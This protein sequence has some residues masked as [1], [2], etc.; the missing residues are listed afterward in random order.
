M[1]P[2]PNE[3]LDNLL[4]RG[5]VLL[6]VHTDQFDESIRHDVVK[7]TLTDAFASDP[8]RNVVNLPLAAERRSDNKAYVHWSGADTV[9]GEEISNG[10]HPRFKLLTETKVAQLCYLGTEIRGVIIHDLKADRHSSVQLVIADVRHSDTCIYISRCSRYAQAYIVACGAVCTPQ[11]L[12]NSNIRP[13][14]LGRNLSEQSIAFCQ[15][16]TTAST[17]FYRSLALDCSQT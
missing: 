5:K 11:I 13:N 14:A 1:N 9:L 10:T 3:E 12:W 4:Q 15:V 2:I 7:N 17:F 6:N 8:T 16:S